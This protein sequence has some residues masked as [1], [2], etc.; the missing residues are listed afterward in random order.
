MCDT[1]Y[2]IY[3]IGWP[4]LITLYNKISK[5]DDLISEF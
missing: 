2:N 4:N 5:I 1:I 3:L